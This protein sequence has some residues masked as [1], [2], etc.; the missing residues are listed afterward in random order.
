VT[1]LELF[2]GLAIAL[3]MVG[4]LFPVLPGSLLILAA[5]GVWAFQ[6]GTGTAFAFAIVCA[7]LLLGGMVVKFAIPGR[8]M[9]ASGVPNTTL[10][11]GAVC[12]IIGFFVIPVLG[13]LV[14]FVLGVYLAEVRRL[15]RQQAWP[16]TKAALKAVGLSIAIEFAS[17]L[18]AACVWGVGV[19]LT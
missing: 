14:G 13:I 18:L 8:R 12:A 15:G 1:A 6:I 4:I 3:G 7:A 9:K 11:I 16:S 17:A 19:A 5:I 10:L 2:V